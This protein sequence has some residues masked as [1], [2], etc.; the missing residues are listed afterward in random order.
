MHKLSYRRSWLE[1]WMRH[2]MQPFRSFFFVIPFIF[3]PLSRHSRCGIKW[4]MCFLLPDFV[5]REMR[6]G[7][8]LLLSTLDQYLSKFITVICERFIF[9]IIS[10]HRFS[11]LSTLVLVEFTDKRMSVVGVVVVVRPWHC[12]IRGFESACALSRHNFVWQWCGRGQRVSANGKTRLLHA[13]PSH[14]LFSFN[15]SILTLSYRAL[16]F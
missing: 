11:I 12:S 8:P 6:S 1:K 13:H 2:E 5:K 4:E 14:M 16:P 3:S 7:S 15:N 9:V 10:I